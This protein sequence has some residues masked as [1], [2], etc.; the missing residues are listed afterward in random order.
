MAVTWTRQCHGLRF[1]YLTPLSQSCLVSHSC[2][3]LSFHNQQLQV[4]TRLASDWHEDI[5]FLPLARGG[6][7]NLRLLEME[8]LPYGKALVCRDVL[9]AAMPSCRFRLVRLMFWGRL[10]CSYLRL[11]QVW[12][13]WSNPGCFWRQ[14]EGTSFAMRIAWIFYAEICIIC[15]PGG[16]SHWGADRLSFYPTEALCQVR[17][18]T[19]YRI[20]FNIPPCTLKL[21][22][23]IKILYMKGT[24][25]KEVV[26]RCMN[27]FDKLK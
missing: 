22:H 20:L 4:W 2:P 24:F 27:T 17:P 11:N 21:C 6:R 10:Q 12:T 9:S 5:G 14:C 1:V 23:F 15:S 26:L 7:S 8:V 16:W 18:K 13:V 3:V 19:S 25:S